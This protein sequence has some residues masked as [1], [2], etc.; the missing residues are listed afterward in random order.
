M[1]GYIRPMKGELKVKE[2]EEYKA[3][4]C[5][6]CK[7]LS[8]HYGVLAKFALSFDMTF[9]AVM[10]LDMSGAKPQVRKGHCVVNPAKKCNF[11]CEGREE[12]HKAAALTVLTVYYKLI[13]NIADEKGIKKLGAKMLKLIVNGAYRKAKADFPR[14]DEIIAKMTEAQTI[15]EKDENYSIDSCSAPTADALAEVFAELAGND[16]MKETVLRQFGYFFGR[17]IYAMD[18]ADDLQKDLKDGSFNPFIRK[19][20]LEGKTEIPEEDREKCDNYCNEV[21]NAN[22]GMMNSALNLLEMGRYENI[23]RNVTELGLAEVQREI[24]FLHIHDK[25]GKKEYERSI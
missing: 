21:L 15:A 8:R 14:F 20:G 1:F 24:L 10:A 16:S 19:L 12:Y 6:L 2:Y 17:W 18:A 5:T 22:A 9:Y 4:Y 3:V 25:K 7:E 13:D 11:I 23:I